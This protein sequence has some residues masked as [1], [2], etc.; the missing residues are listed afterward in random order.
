MPQPSFGAIPANTIINGHSND[1]GNGNSIG[2]GVGAV[3][4]GR[5]GGGVKVFKPA[6]FAP[7]SVLS[8]H[9]GDVAN[10]NNVNN[11]NDGSGGDGGNGGGGGGF[12]SRFGRTDFSKLKVTAPTGRFAPPLLKKGKHGGGGDKV[13][14]AAAAAA[15]KARN[16]QA[17]VTPPLSPTNSDDYNRD[18]G[19]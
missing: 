10:N 18:D 15:A 9:N 8:N 14:A 4:G 19:F 11:S 1:D 3:G 6:V 2:S 5:G 16:Y 13:D 17:P 12:A 7:P